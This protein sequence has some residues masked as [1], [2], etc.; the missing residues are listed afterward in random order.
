LTKDLQKL[1]ASISAGEGCIRN[2]VSS[3]RKLSRR[4]EWPTPIISVFT[5]CR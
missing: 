2:L 4:Q 1:L 3:F 5:M